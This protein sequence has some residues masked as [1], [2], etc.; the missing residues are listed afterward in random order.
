MSMILDVEWLEGLLKGIT[1]VLLSIV[2][3]LMPFFYWLATSCFQLLDLCQL[4]FRYMSGL[5]AYKLIG[6]TTAQSG[7]LFFRLFE[8]IFLSGGLKGGFFGTDGEYSVLAI[9]FWSLVII[10]AL[11]L[12]VTTIAAIIRNEY[13][14]DKEKKNSKSG[15]IKNFFKALISFAIV[16]IA[17]YFGLWLGNAVL[18]AIDSATTSQIASNLTSAD[19]KDKFEAT[20]GS[21]CYLTAGGIV[22]VLP[23]GK[24]DTISM[25]YPSIS[26]IVN[27]TCLYSAN[28]VR[29]EDGFYEGQ[30]MSGNLSLGVFDKVSG[31][32]KCA[33]LI[34][35]A[36][37]LNA[38][39]KNPVN[40]VTF[41]NRNDRDLVKQYYNLEN[42]N[43]ILAVI[44][45]FSGYK[46]ILSFAFGLISR[47]LML[48][49]LLF[50]EPIALSFM[51]IDNGGAFNLWRKHYVGRIISV[52]AALLS[53]NVFYIVC[54]VFLTINFFDAAYTWAN[55]I[56]Q[57]IF[58]IGL[59]GAIKQLDGLFNKIIVSDEK[60]GG[61]M[62]VSTGGAALMKDTGEAFGKVGKL[63]STGVK[64]GAGVA[65]AGIRAGIGVGAGITGA[66]RAGQEHK[67][68]KDR[69][70]AAAN[71]DAARKTMMDKE[72]VMNKTD[73]DI[74]NDASGKAKEE[75]GKIG[76]EKIGEAYEKYASKAGDNALSLDDWKEQTGEGSYM[77][78]HSL[79]G[80]DKMTD[81]EYFDKYHAGGTDEDFNKWKEEG[82]ALKQQ[83]KDLDLKQKDASAY[84]AEKEVK[85]Q[86]GSEEE[87]VANSKKKMEDILAGKATANDAHEAAME[88]EVRNGIAEREKAKEEYN[89]AKLDVAK[90]EREYKQKETER[91]EH[92]E[93]RKGAFAY[94]RQNGGKVF[95][96]AI[97]DTLAALGE[98]FVKDKK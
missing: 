77:H 50:I 21:Y 1:N 56:V 4:L 30:I 33:E 60:F 15:I 90:Y 46:V 53:M 36:F 89:K 73:K 57:A 11:L 47:V 26:G 45:I 58:I 14:P 5:E 43:I 24:Y 17:S 49:G 3:L 93:E 66:V 35:D 28:R 92:K 13:N 84:T 62:A 7:D 67:A 86:Y 51:P 10:G 71:A 20:N 61:E 39:L 82:K 78:A 70:T 40:N 6:D 29:A 37:S 59:L 55:G 2:R 19:V 27:K 96:H 75:Y 22:S 83:Y 94:M 64:L 41:L 34:D 97:G 74:I 88:R 42:Y 65:K 25:K 18:F 52:F 12:L 48:L 38:K 69:D 85:K 44:Y 23:N 98:T 79:V 76:D 91:K 87:Y 32:A 81:R 31:E 95:K 16:P 72:K 63:A 54:P 68:R 8:K 80:K 9:A